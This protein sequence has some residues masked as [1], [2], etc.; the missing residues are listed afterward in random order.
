MT[1]WLAGTLLLLFVAVQQFLPWKV[2]FAVERRIA[3]KP[4]CGS[5]LT[6]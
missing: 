2:M 1:R 3:T 4:V 6:L 5:M